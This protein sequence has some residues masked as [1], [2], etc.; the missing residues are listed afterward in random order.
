MKISIKF[1][2]SRNCGYV[3]IVI[4]LISNVIKFAIIPHE[5]KK[6]SQ[7]APMETKS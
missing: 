4:K 3:G 1:Q 5:N 7:K 2:F 6:V